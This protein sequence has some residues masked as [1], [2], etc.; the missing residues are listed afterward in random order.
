MFSGYNGGVR[1]S[2]RSKAP[3][4]TVVVILLA[5]FSAAAAS[6]QVSDQG[7]VYIIPIKGEINRSLMVFLSRHVQEARDADASHVI[8][9]IDTFGGRVDSALQITTIIGS[10]Q[11]IPTTAY[12]P[13]LS[14]GTGVSWSAGALISLACDAI[15]VAPGTSMGSAAPILQGPDGAS[16]PADEK[17]VSAVRTQMA[18]LAEKNGYPVPIAK[19]MV[20][21]DLEVVELVVD[22]KS[23][24]IDA[25]ELES[26][27]ARAEEAGQSA[28]VGA[29]ISSSGKLLSLTAGEMVRYGV[30][31]ALASSEAE[32]IEA[33]GA[34]SSRVVR[35][36]PT[37]ADQAISLLTS[38]GLTSL[39]ILIGLVALFAEITSPGFGVP[40]TIGILC[41]AVIFAANGLMGRVGSFELLMFIVGTVLLILEVF[42]IPGFGIAGISGIALIAA[43]LILS[44]QTFVLPSFEWEWRA[45]HMNVLLVVGNLLGALISIGVIA[46]F[47]PR[48]RFFSRLVLEHAQDSD[49]GFTAQAPEESSYV[50]MSGVATSTLR[51]SGKVRIGDEVVVVVSDGEFLEPG[52]PIVVAAADGNRIVVRRAE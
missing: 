52:T 48:F 22:G 19:A 32:V 45:F 43:S 24:P 39:L 9:E 34:A 47:V 4:A 23:I 27:I 42:V 31:T 36:E 11:S 46:H 29:T 28:A 35:V 37:P 7:P 21:I 49:A 10:L 1:A 41:F 50:G 40:G 33:L 15:Y 6:A 12:I 17:T 20:D 51:P 3:V 16:I 5:L 13:I 18:A 30:A 8:F 25:N 26:R 38:A 2:V 44:L 14:E